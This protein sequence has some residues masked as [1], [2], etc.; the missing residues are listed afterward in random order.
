MVK[1][2]VGKLGVKGGRDRWGGGRGTACEVSKGWEG[3][4]R[5]PARTARRGENTGVV[6]EMGGPRKGRGGD[7]VGRGEDAARQPFQIT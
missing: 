6:G 7:M 4:G 1:I 5:A 3:V 2:S